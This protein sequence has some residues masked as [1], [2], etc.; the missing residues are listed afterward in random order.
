MEDRL[1][2]A[3]ERL[4]AEGVTFTELGVQRIVAEAKTA[5][6]TFYMHF[7][8]KTE[9]LLRL[10]TA[11]REQSFALVSQWQTSEEADSEDLAHLY[12]MVIAL[13]REHGAVLAAVT[14]VAAYDPA[15]Q[16]FWATQLDRF[17]AAT[18]ERLRQDQQK[19]RL[20]PRLDPLT[21]AK[22]IVRGGDRVITQH[23]AED[24]GSSDAAVAQELA[25][26]QWYGAFRRPAE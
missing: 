1:L 3:T 2:A 4:L 22:V 25:R 21:A 6:S 14:E 17:S 18:A 9:L 13:Y 5:R 26:L 12:E 23:I 8:D 20:D 19:G 11:L 15:V 24:D 7:R 16:A 10:A